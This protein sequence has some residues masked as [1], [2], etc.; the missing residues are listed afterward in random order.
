M[1]NIFWVNSSKSGLCD[2]LLDL[3]LMAALA[4]I[5]NCNLILKWELFYSSSGGYISSSKKTKDL[6]ITKYNSRRYEDY[7]YE[8]FTQYFTVP[9]NVIVLQDSQIK[10]FEIN[11]LFQDYI[12]GVHSVKTFW[13]KYLSQKVSFQDFLFIY[14]N[15]L[16]QFKPTQKLLE[17]VRS[18]KIPKLSVHLRRTDK[19]V[20]N[21]DPY[22][23]S[24]LE[25]LN[26]KTLDSINSFIQ[27]N[28]ED[29]TIYF[30]SDD[31]EER[32]N[33]ENRYKNYL[34]EKNLEDLGFIN[35]YIDMFLLSSSETIILSQKH[36]NFS[37]FCALIGKTRLIYLYDD[38]P[39][40]DLQYPSFKNFINYKYT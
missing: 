4:K 28:G 37:I 29:V 20:V 19:V 32:N 8:N 12:G 22:G 26:K 2:R 17:I 27:K 25:E 18:I 36:S 15:I 3:S 39:I 35:T 1:D 30:S 9:Q 34:V 24:D 10:D 11:L 7:L 40:V 5:L 13:E 14:D 6:N 33:Y 31:H 16:S 38:C 23:I 21:P